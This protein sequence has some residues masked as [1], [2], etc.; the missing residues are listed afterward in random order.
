MIIDDNVVFLRL[1]G[2]GRIGCAKTYVV[3]ASLGILRFWFRTPS[4][5]ITVTTTNNAH[6]IIIVVDGPNAEEMTL[7]VRQSGLL[8]VYKVN[9]LRLSFPMVLSDE[10]IIFAPIA[11][12]SRQLRLLRNNTCSFP[13]Y[14]VR[15]WSRSRPLGGFV[16][17]QL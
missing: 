14:I 12:S 16:R 5:V 6:L 4:K 13:R 3:D 15:P 17:V 9:G 10:I 2:L 8:R 7:R 1:R 11:I